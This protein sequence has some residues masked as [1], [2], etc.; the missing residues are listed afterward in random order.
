VANSPPLDSSAHLVRLFSRR[1]ASALFISTFG[2]AAST[3]RL[4]VRGL[5]GGLGER[6]PRPTS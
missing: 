2:R 4:G 5:T 6:P 3:G 1:T